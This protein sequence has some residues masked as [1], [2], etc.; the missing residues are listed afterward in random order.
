MK[1]QET[2]YGPLELGAMVILA[3]AGFVLII[4]IATQSISARKILE[5]RVYITI[6]FLIWGMVVAAIKGLTPK[7][8]L[9]AGQIVLAMLSNY[10]QVNELAKVEA[11]GNLYDR[12]TFIAAGLAIVVAGFGK[13]FEAEDAERAENKQ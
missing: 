1:R 13:V 4:A 5:W 7:K 3:A 8:V 11:T 10:H 12:L 9:A 6:A 2:G